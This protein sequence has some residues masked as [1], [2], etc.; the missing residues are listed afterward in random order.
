M[1][2]ASCVVCT[3]EA[4]HKIH[5]LPPLSLSL[6][7]PFSIV[8]NI[9]KLYCPPSLGPS[10]SLTLSLLNTHMPLIISLSLYLCPQP[11]SLSLSLFSFP[12]I[13]FSLT[14]PLSLS[15]SPYKV[16]VPHPVTASATL[17]DKWASQCALKSK[18]SQS[19]NNPF[20]ENRETNFKKLL[21]MSSSSKT[22]PHRKW[23]GIYLHC[24]M[25]GGMGECMHVHYIYCSNYIH[26]YMYMPTHT[27]AKSKKDK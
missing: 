10:L 19:L 4:L 23:H 11:P 6:F 5:H 3:G 18:H 24:L 14:L 12:I 17:R 8:V 1:T 25:Q 15:L 7:L 9:N 21:S 16:Y 20:C 26:A 27:Y 13:S 22:S 2:M